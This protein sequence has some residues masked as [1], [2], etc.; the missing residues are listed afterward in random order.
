M[1][2]DDD[3][4]DG[5]EGLN[6]FALIFGILVILVIVLLSAMLGWF[7]RGCFGRLGGGGG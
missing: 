3:D 1:A 5:G 2:H 6:E 4:N 7:Y